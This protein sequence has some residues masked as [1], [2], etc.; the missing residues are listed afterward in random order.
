MEFKAQAEH[1]AASLASSS[2]R[3][4][5]VTCRSLGGVARPLAAATPRVMTVKAAEEAAEVVDPVTTTEE[6]RDAG[7]DRGPAGATD[8]IEGVVTMTRRLGSEGSREGEV[9]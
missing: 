3:H 7:A 8:A 9:T 4:Y 2:G 6:G 5:N 1:I